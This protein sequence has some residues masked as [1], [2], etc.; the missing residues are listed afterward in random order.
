VLQLQQYHRVLIVTDAWYPQ[1]NGVVRTLDTI[2]R[3]LR[4]LG[5]DVHFITPDLFTSIPCPTYPEIRLAILPGRKM[6]RIIE[7]WQPCVIHV[8]TEGPVG[9]AARRYCQKRGLPFTT[10]FHTRFPEYIEARSGIPARWIYPS[11]RHFHNAADCIM[12]ATETLRSELG[13]LGFRNLR[14]WGRGVDVELF[15]PRDKAFLN[16]PRPIY[17]Y[18]GRVAVEKNIKD[19]LDLNMPGSKVVVGDGPLLDA[20]R[21][22]YPSV[23]FVGAKQDEELA[24]YYAA[25]D[26]FVFPSRTDTFGNVVL[27]ALASG[28]PVAAYPVPGPKDIIGGTEVGALDVDL[29][30]A[31]QKALSISPEA[32]RAFALTY[33]WRASAEQFLDNVIPFDSEWQKAAQG[34]VKPVAKTS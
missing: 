2:G 34:R 24:R 15:K 4:R 29:A 11:L 20:L 22:D 33:S 30:R 1:V 8:A 31:A 19:F 13:A 5:H 32:C 12:V 10:S 26:V 6:A 3:E 7:A 23:R 14:I 17:L 18:V 21:R 27:E 28:V 25:A 9:F 16:D